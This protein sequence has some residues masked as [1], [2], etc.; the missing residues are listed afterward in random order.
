V[1]REVHPVVIVIVL[2]A[3]I[4]VLILLWRLA[5]RVS[6]PPPDSRL[7]LVIGQVVLLTPIEHSLSYENGKPAPTFP[8]SSPRPAPRLNPRTGGDDCALHNPS[9]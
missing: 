7:P 5:G 8:T 1:K 2:I 9:Q 6:E 3:A 4:V